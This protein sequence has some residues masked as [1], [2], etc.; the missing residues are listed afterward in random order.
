[1]PLNKSA[2]SIW[3]QRGRSNTAFL[4]L[5]YS[6][7]NPAMLLEEVL[8]YFLEKGEMTLLCLLLRFRT[9]LGMI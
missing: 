7:K 5:F 4:T 6:N 1:M 8:L 3:V 2:K 9:K